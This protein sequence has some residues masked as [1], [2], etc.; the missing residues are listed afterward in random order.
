MF[1]KTVTIS[2]SII[3][4]C[5]LGKQMNSLNILFLFAID[6]MWQFSKLIEIG[7]VSHKTL[8]LE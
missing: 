8:S 1:D 6:K 7:F 2:Y 3:F 4:D 5:I